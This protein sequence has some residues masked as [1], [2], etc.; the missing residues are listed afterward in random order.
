MSNSTKSI[1]VRTIKKSP[2]ELIFTSKVT[3]DKSVNTVITKVSPHRIAVSK[4]SSHS[5]ICY[6]SSKNQSP[7]CKKTTNK[8]AVVDLKKLKPV[9]ITM[10]EQSECRI[11]NIDEA[12]RI[13]ERTEVF[14]L[15][16]IIREFRF[17]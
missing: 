7:N 11:I 3:T 1:T 6:P 8:Q 4:G 12:I 5:V 16:D 13:I 2:R 10:C 9:K 15:D 17:Y 14:S